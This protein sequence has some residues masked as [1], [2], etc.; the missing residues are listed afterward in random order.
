MT[1]NPFQ[2]SK[3]AT[4]PRARLSQ[5][6]PTTQSQ[7]PLATSTSSIGVSNFNHR[8]LA[9]VCDC[10]KTVPATI[11]NE[12]HPYLHEKDLKDFC[13]QKGVLFQAY[14]PLGSYDRPWAKPG[15]PELLEDPRLKEVAKKYGKTPA[16]VG[17]RVGP[18]FPFF[19]ATLSVLFS[20]S[21]PHFNFFRP[22]LLGGASLAH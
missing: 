21:N 13:D 14:S 18:K 19:C 15:D 2:K 6:T 17:A 12:C 9:E 4:S 5:Q 11:Q 20:F 1:R 16:Q 8:Q 3:N 10:S 7:T 22:T